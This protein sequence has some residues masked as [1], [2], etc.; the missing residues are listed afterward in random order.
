MLE[1]RVQRHFFETADLANQAA[2]ALS[3]PVSRAAEALCACLTGGG[4]LL[5]AGSDVGAWLAPAI[6]AA[7][8]GR[9]E[10]ERPPLAALPL[11][12][13]PASPLAQQVRALGHPG[14]VLLAVDGGGDTLALAGAV[15]AARELEMTVVLVTGSGHP[16]W[17][18]ELAD[19]DVLVTIPHERA[20]RVAEAQL[21]VLHSL[22]DAVDF[23]LMGEQE[24]A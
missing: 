2:E 3:R 7:F 24:S 5:A 17:Q 6:C 20:C 16:G 21:L 12:E 11:R 8:T 1:Q 19:T 13:D 10:R 14:D 22:C 15:A 9:F 18:D 4:K 23:Q